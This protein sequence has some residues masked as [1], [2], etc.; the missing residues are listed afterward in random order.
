[1][2][3]ALAPAA[4]RTRIALT[5]ARA[6]RGRGRVGARP[7][8][9]GSQRARRAPRRRRTHGRDRRLVEHARVL[10][11]DREVAAHARKRSVTAGRARSRLAER[12]HGPAARDAGLGSARLAADDR[13]HQRAEPQARRQGEA[14]SDAAPRSCSRRLPVGRGLH[15]WH[16][17]VDRPGAG[18]PGAARGGHPPRP[19]R[20]R[21]RPSRRAGGSPAGRRAHHAHARARDRRFASSR[22]A[23]ARATPRSSPIS[24]ARHSSWTRPTP[25]TPRSARRRCGRSRPRSRSSCSVSHSPLLLALSEPLLP[26][27]WRSTPGG[28]P[29]DAEPLPPG[30][31]SGA[32]PRARDRMR[33]PR[34]A[35]PTDAASAYPRR[36]GANGSV[37]SSP[38]PSHRLD[39][40][41]G[42]EK[43]CSGCGGA[44]TCCGPTRPTGPGSRT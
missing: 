2:R 42:P 25:S 15:G 3:S 10:E 1:M 19:D 40:H 6:G 14:R 18:H 17:A 36:G 8:A 31:S 34:T 44:A 22:W 7:R 4:R 29:D 5:A 41:S 11:H 24:V 27:R 43:W 32:P 33:V 21:Q 23:A 39:S 30:R 12:V 28:R 38:P 16:P 35:E 9:P 13:L 26:L 37:A 20:A